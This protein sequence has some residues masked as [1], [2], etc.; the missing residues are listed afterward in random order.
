MWCQV[1]MALAV[2]MSAAQANDSFFNNFGFF[3][4]EP[5]HALDGHVIKTLPKFKADCMATCKETLSCFSINTYKDQ[6]GNNMC[7]LNRSTKKQ[8]SKS[9]VKRIGYDYSEPSVSR[10]DIAILS[11]LH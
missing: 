5:D 2:A 4:I 3:D 10:Y 11:N 1:I 8:S 7:D 6:L 9:F